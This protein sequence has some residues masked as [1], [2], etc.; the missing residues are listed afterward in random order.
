MISDQDLREKIEMLVKCLLS[1]TV[2]VFHMMKLLVKIV[3]IKLF[4]R[5][6]IFKNVLL[7]TCVIFVIEN[8]IEGTLHLRELFLTIKITRFYIYITSAQ[9]HFEDFCVHF[10]KWNIYLKINK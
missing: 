1:F 6:N 4:A 8:I 3:I 7:P 10:W 2:I 5:I 9:K